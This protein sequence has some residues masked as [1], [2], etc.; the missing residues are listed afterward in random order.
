M[1]AIARSKVASLAMN[2]HC[3]AAYGHSHE[4]DWSRLG[5]RSRGWKIQL[6]QLDTSFA[7]GHGNWIALWRVLIDWMFAET[8]PNSKQR[9]YPK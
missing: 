5:D 3:K 1:G 8:R 7:D 4:I 6:W 9:S 2:K